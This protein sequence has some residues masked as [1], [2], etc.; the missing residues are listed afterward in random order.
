MAITDN[1]PLGVCEVTF[2][3]TLNGATAPVI[4]DTTLRDEDTNFASE[5]SLFE[6]FVDQLDGSYM[7]NHIAGDTPATF[8]CSVFVKPSDLPNL[9]ATYEVNGAG[10]AVTM[11]ASGKNV[12]YGT[13]SIHP[14][15]MG[16]DLSA[17]VTGFKVAC[18]VALD[19]NYKS[20]DLAKADLTFNFSSEQDKASEYYGKT[21]V[22]GEYNAVLEGVPRITGQ[23]PSELTITEGDKLYLNIATDPSVEFLGTTWYKDGAV[24]QENSDLDY[25]QDPSAMIDAGVYTVRVG[26]AIGDTYSHP[27]TVTIV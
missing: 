19:L 24:V 15:S 3:A 21:F 6:V 11:G 27:C 22:I 17:N 9:T 10:T 20:E 16:A 2:D 18:S 26:N 4:I 8:T 23:M 1:L 13:L 25:T 7:A 12:M 14:L 5:T